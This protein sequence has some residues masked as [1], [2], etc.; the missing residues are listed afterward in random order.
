MSTALPSTSLHPPRHV[1]ELTLCRPDYLNSFLDPVKLF[2]IP[3]V[4][5]RWSL[6]SLAPTGVFTAWSVMFVG[7]YYDVPAPVLTLVEHNTIMNAFAFSWSAATNVW[8]TT[9]VAQKAWC[10]PTHF[11]VLR[12]EG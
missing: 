12:A 6:T 1:R 3:S 7:F 8:A 5:A 9:M 11:H 2:A 4:P 10:V